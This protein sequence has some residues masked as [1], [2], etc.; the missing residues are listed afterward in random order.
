MSMR[1]QAIDQKNKGYDPVTLS[2]WLWF[3]VACFEAS[4]VE[5]Q[6]LFEKIIKR[7]DPKFISIKPYGNLGDR[8]CD[9]LFFVESESTVFQVY[10]PDNIK[11][12]EILKKINEDFNGAKKHWGNSMHKWIFVYNARSG[13]PADI[14]LKLEHMKKA[15]KKIQ[16]ETIS[17]DELW[18]MARCLSIQQRSEILGAPIQ[19]EDTSRSNIVVLQ[20]ILSPITFTS[21]ESTLSPN[22]VF[23]RPISLRP[24]PDLSWSEI[25]EFQKE[26]VTELIKNTQEL[27]LDYAVF[28]LAPIPLIIQLGF[29]LSDRVEVNQFQFDR[30]NQS[31]KWPAK[32]T[33]NG[34][35]KSSGVPTEKISNENIVLRISLSASIRKEQTEPIIKN[36]IEVDIY[37]DDPNILW[38][39][40]KRQ[41]KDFQQEF[42]GVLS[43]IRKYASDTK[44][45][46][47][48]YAGPA[49]AALALGQAINPRMDPIVYTYEYS[50][51]TD[52][53]YT[54]AITLE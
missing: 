11:L 5:F 38:L 13:I 2:H 39:Q 16:F 52:P 51:K 20:D 21:I 19:A 43:A 34:I 14:P 49:S 17:N 40:T 3:K 35:V 15:N 10:S 1:S 9:G 42:Y 31:W 23:G 7:V 29:L 22:T 18:E 12:A 28:S 6:H 36:A 27:S 32:T 41:L 30:I 54:L 4:G 25:G 53:E 47:I 46:H 37:V 45:L 24:R 26:L 48:F 50:R 8:K 44:A 33:Q